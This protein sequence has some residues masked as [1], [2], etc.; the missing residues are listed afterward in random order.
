MTK[1]T[2]A[3][4]AAKLLAFERNTNTIVAGPTSSGK[5]TLL[6]NILTDG[7]FEG[8]LPKHVY[9]LCPT[10]TE[11]EWTS[12]T[13]GFTRFPTTVIG[14]LHSLDDFLSRSAQVPEESMIIFDDYMSVLDNTDRR[15]KMES[16]FYVTTHHRHCWTFFVLHDIFNKNM[17]TMRRNT[18]NFI[19]FNVL[20]SDFR[21]GQEFSTRLLGAAAGSAFVSL[22]SVIV[23]DH[24][25]GWVRIDQKTKTNS[26]LKTVVSTGGISVPTGGKLVLRSTTLTSPLYADSMSSPA[27]PDSDLYI[28]P[29][30]L[31]IRGSLHDQQQD[32]GGTP[33]TVATS[34]PSDG[35]RDM[36][37]SH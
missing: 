4:T 11:S 16:W 36:H 2:S 14:G 22:W 17:T 25:N 1:V 5:S 12:R 15:R 24:P 27:V 37:L 35:E 21:S 7:S 32:G 10:E 23:R 26:P 34:V 33:Q 28:V 3:V 20:Q 30:H 29:E 8:G 18:Q 19:L 6:M 9:I 31:I 13:E